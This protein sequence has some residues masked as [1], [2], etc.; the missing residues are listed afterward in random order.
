MCCSALCHYNKT[1]KHATDK[2]DV[3]LADGFGGSKAQFY[4]PIHF[5]WHLIIMAV[6][7]RGSLDMSQ[8]MIT[9]QTKSSSSWVELI[10]ACAQ[11][12]SQVLCRVSQEPPSK[13]WSWWCKGIPPDPGFHRFYHLLRVPAQRVIFLSL[14][15]SGDTQVPLKQ[16]V[17]HQFEFNSTLPKST[18]VQ[19]GLASSERNII[20]MT[21]LQSGPLNVENAFRREDQ[22]RLLRMGLSK[23]FWTLL[24]WLEIRLFPE[25]LWEVGQLG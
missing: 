23:F 20:C 4:G 3:Y 13:A 14:R 8:P 7:S 9:S 19:G 10:L 12:L 18:L 11:T 1:P 22:G 6:D 21:E 5:Q 15:P 24:L 17:S 25:D 2:K 16:A